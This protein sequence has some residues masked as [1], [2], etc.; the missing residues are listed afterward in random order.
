M[1]Q[2]AGEVLTMEEAAAEIINEMTLSEFIAAL[3]IAGDKLGKSL[4][5]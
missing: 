1:V 4:E 2:T 3:V 5:R